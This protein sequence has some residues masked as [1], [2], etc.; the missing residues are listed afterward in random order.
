MLETVPDGP[1]SD[2]SFLCKLGFLRLSPNRFEIDFSEG[3]AKGKVVIFLRLV[4]LVV[5]GIFRKELTVCLNRNLGFEVESGLL[6]EVV[7]TEVLARG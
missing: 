1:L 2:L 3:L 4:C 7:D 6:I 5:I